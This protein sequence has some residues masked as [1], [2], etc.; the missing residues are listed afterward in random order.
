MNFPWFRLVMVAMFIAG[1]SI[2]WLAHV[3]GGLIV[4]WVIF[5][6]YKKD[7]PGG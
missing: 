2:P 5:G 4:L 7:S 3:S 6:P 1:F